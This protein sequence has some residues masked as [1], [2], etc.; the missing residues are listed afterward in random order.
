MKPVISIVGRPNVGKSTLFN[1]ILGFKKAITEDTPGVTRD[2]NYGEFDYMGKD[3]ILVDTGGFEPSKE[4]GFS[5]LIEQQ[6]MA[7][8]SESDIAIFV[9][10]GKDGMLHEDHDVAM[11]LRKWNKPVFY[12][13]NKVDSKQREDVIADFY[14]IG[15]EQLYP[16]SALHGMGVDDL[17]EDI[18][19]T[20]GDTF[21]KEDTAPEQPKPI[22]IAIVGK[23]NTGKSSLTNRLL[24]EERMIVSELAGTTRDSIDSPII[25]DEKEFV[26]IDTAG[27]R[28]KSKIS[29]KVEE[30]SVS[31]AIR[32]I[33]RANIVNLVID[34]VEGAGHQEGAIA[35]LII[36]R[37]KGI[38][39]VV[40]KWDLVSG[41]TRQDE[42][43][44][45]IRER[46]P[47]ASFAPVVFISAK[48]GK[49]VDAVLKTNL[50][51]HEQ[52]TRRIA[53]ADINKAFGDFFNK[54]SISHQK[55]KQ[56]K[57]FYVSQT[58][59]SPPT[60]ILFS[61]HPELIPEN[62]KRYLENSIR[63]RFGFAGAPV[64]L[65]FKKK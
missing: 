21:D 15:A 65:V 36:S 48:T 62:Y 56:V 59:A 51:I 46:I 18:V 63:A 54:L 13:V 53:T 42:Y 41:K 44:Q 28:K 57:I 27:L 24:G 16:V 45:M 3:F 43:K 14:K 5:P 31:S 11:V 20:I 50:T 32:S 6:I 23:P 22:N 8:L 37:G 1:R 52:L 2:R 33:E 19:K 55:N 9:L 29:V 58:K 25:V 47:H 7:S 35:H 12:A 17:L 39:I 61:N 4:D 10:D 60:F 40:N 34:A 38:C 49:N 64:R 30:Y 26:L